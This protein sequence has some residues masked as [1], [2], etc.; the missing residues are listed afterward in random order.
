MRRTEYQVTATIDSRDFDNNP[1]FSNYLI[2]IANANGAIWEE[3]NEEICN[4]VFSCS[5]LDRKRAKEI[6][7]KIKK[8]YKRV[9]VE[10]DIEN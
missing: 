1:S 7:K 8:N 5:F 4:I 3:G 2:N 10:I 9:T 6:A